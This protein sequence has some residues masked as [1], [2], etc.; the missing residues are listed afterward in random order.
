MY[1]PT[2]PLRVGALPPDFNVIRLRD[3]C[4]HWSLHFDLAPLLAYDFKNRQEAQQAS[5]PAGRRD[6]QRD[7][8]GHWPQ[9]TV[10]MAKNK[11]RNWRAESAENLASAAGLRGGIGY[12]SGFYTAS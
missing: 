1:S 4:N 11:A 5:S 2:L 3:A 9:D 6:R 12:G 10:S 7:H 8:H